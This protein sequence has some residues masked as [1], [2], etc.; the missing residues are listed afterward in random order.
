M[1]AKLITFAI[2]C[3]ANYI[4]KEAVKN[5]RSFLIHECMHAGQQ[6]FMA[7]RV[8]Y[9]VDGTIWSSRLALLPI[10]NDQK[11]PPPYMGLQNVSLC[12]EVWWTKCSRNFVVIY[13]L[14]FAQ[15]LASAWIL[16]TV[17]LNV[18]VKNAYSILIVTYFLEAERKVLSSLWAMPSVSHY[19]GATAISQES[20]KG[21]KNCFAKLNGEMHF[22]KIV[23]P[24]PH[25]VLNHFLC[26]WV[27]ERG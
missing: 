24:T 3:Q 2:W 13:E 22:K 6:L 12:I 11:T 16:S 23:R 14:P 5:Q 8:Y 10:N 26:C 20:T 1:S 19:Q 15:W 27:R 21:L 9:V 18:V 17:K 25:T 4:K 7:Q